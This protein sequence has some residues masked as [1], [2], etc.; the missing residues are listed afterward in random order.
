MPV[1]ADE[2]V[3][4]LEGI[5][6]Y[7]LGN[8]EAV[9]GHVATKDQAECRG[10][11][12]Q[13]SRVHS[14][15]C[16]HKICAVRKHAHPLADGCRVADSGTPVLDTWYSQCLPCRCTSAASASLSQ[17]SSPVSQGLTPCR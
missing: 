6:N 17:R 8:W 9:A 2:E 1:Q 5:D 10:H 12:T 11:Y 16:A 3:L 13:V 14:H 15:V 7:G 4:L